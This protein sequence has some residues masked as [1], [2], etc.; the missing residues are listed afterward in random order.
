MDHLYI[1]NKSRISIRYDISLQNNI[2]LMYALED[3][4]KDLYG[5][6][7]CT[8]S[9]NTA[10]CYFYFAISPNHSAEQYSCCIFNNT[11]TYASSDILGLIWAVYDFCEKILAVNPFRK[12][13]D[14]D[15]QKL[16]NVC[17]TPIKR[18]QKPVYKYR[19]WFFNDEDYLTGWRPPAGKRPVDYLFYSN[20][21]NHKTVDELTETILRNKFNL[22]I[23]S[24]FLDIDMPE[25]EENVRRITER[26]LFISQHHI[27]PLG[28]SRFAFE[29]YFK[30]KGIAKQSTSYYS[31]IEAYDEVWRHYVKKWARYKN[32]IWQVGLR[33]KL[34][35]PVWADDRSISNEKFG[36]KLISDAIS[37]QL[38]II[39][40][41]TKNEHPIATMTLWEEGAELYRKGYLV[42]PE[43]VII[44]FTDWPRTQLMRKDFH[45]IERK[46]NQKY[47][48]Y[49]HTGSFCAGPHAVQGTMPEQMQ[50]LFKITTQKG[51]TEF[52]ISNVQNLRELVYTTYLMSKFAFYGYQLTVNKLSLEWCKSILP[53]RAKELKL[54]YK[55]FYSAYLENKWD[56]YT[57]EGTTYWF[58]GFIRLAGLYAI[59]KY[60]KNVW[61]EFFTAERADAYVVEME[62]C[63]KR[64]SAVAR[65]IE[66][67]CKTLDGTAKIFVKDNLFIQAKIMEILSKWAY[68]VNI[69]IKSDR[70]GNLEKAVNCA[71]KA[72]SVL[73]EILT[74]LPQ[75]EHGKFK[76]W[77]NN[78]DKF[79][80]KRMLKTT[81][82]LLDFLRTSPQKR[83]F[84]EN[85]PETD[86]DYIL[87]YK[88]KLG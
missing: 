31:A 65:N 11:V 78:E 7:D 30:R 44:V 4:K 51:D 81:N 41:I 6:L 35:R 49:H 43:E 19:G 21:M 77:Y 13:L 82:D 3:L 67:F 80:Y 47:G 55:K 72:I 14:I 16:K 36:G 75:C 20:I 70:N 27:E 58:D 28:V 61:N 86:G 84:W 33:G 76:G 39:K 17:I 79:D 1:Y 87:N 42:V 85:A 9:D 66:D 22:I 52:F 69:A 60:L 53:N 59:D 56:E 8:F 40:E 71:E 46:P 29:G 24:S 2:A 83:I 26:G 34:D 74:I 54:I 37:H 64:W 5:V 45:Q 63:Y 57:L 88:Y 25:D 15:Y 23:P 62:I 18:S 12:F 32:I 68:Y 73:T 48:V 38:R 50:N 10:D